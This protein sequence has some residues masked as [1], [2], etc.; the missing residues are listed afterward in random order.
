MSLDF[1]IRIDGAAEMAPPDTSLCE[2]E[3]RQTCFI[4]HEEWCF[5]ASLLESGATWSVTQQVY[6]RNHK[7]RAMAFML[8]Y[9][10]V[11]A[12]DER[13]DRFRRMLVTYGKPKADLSSIIG[14]INHL[15]QQYP[16]AR[17]RLDMPPPGCDRAMVLG[18]WKDLL[19]PEAELS[20]T[21]FLRYQ[22]SFHYSI[23][24]SWEPI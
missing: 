17:A 22:P 2:L 13:I 21:E 23:P 20:A 7:Q 18:F 3:N 6:F 9:L 24:G 4:A 11:Q 12:R 16:G 14:A 15:L 10:V 8:P 19:E 1:A 5:E